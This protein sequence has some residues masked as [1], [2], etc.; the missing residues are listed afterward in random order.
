M[1]LHWASDVLV[2]VLVVAMAVGSAAQEASTS[3][4]PRAV[5]VTPKQVTAEVGQQLK[6]TAVAKNAAGEV[7]PGE[8]SLWFA[9]PFDLAGAEKGVVT[10]YQP[11]EIRVGAVIAGKTGY[12]TV[13]V[14]PPPPKTVD[15]VS[16]GPIVVGGSRVLQATARNEKGD[17]QQNA[18]IA[19]SSETPSIASV[20]KAGVVVGLRPGQAKVR[21]TSGKASGEVSFAVEKNP[22]A[23]LNVQPST[24]Q[25]KTGDVVRFTPQ[26]KDCRLYTSPS[27]RDRG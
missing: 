1:R 7:I 23:S 6:F 20:D 17:P 19:W 13:T 25:A 18:P 5:E 12:A 14:L 22:V 2:A 10:V 3:E 16:P 8:P 24:A 4:I 26:A 15:I 9:A 27:P 21:A 11:G